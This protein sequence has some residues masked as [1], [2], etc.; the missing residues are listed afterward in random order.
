MKHALQ[1][2]LRQSIVVATLIAIALCALSPDSYS[3]EQNTSPQTN[4]TK[5]NVVYWYRN[6]DMTATYQ[7]LKLALDKT[8]DLFGEAT[9]QRSS[10][11]TQGRAVIDIET[12]ESSITLINVIADQHREDKLRPIYMASDDSLGGLRVCVIRR[13]DQEKF[14]GIRS[15][16]DLNERNITFGQG[17]HWPD[18]RILASNGLNVVQGAKYENLFTMLQGERFNCFLRGIGEVFHDLEQHGESDL[19]IESSLLFSYPSASIF[20]VRKNDKALA[21]RIELGLRRALLDGSYTDFFDNYYKHNIDQLNLHKRRIIRLNN[22]LISETMLLK[23]SE[24][25][26]LDDGKLEAY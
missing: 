4:D 14:S 5:L 22:P 6:F 17:A 26:R 10:E 19:Q 21:A 20:F 1:P 9:I 25:L 2:H 18:A 16:N 24:K 3:N 7:V 23:T 8:T 11:M 12:G 13:G 15:L